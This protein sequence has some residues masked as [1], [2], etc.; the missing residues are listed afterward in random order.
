MPN[1]QNGK[2][3]AIISRNPASANSR[4]I[5]STTVSLGQ[6]MAIHR[7]MHRSGAKKVASHIILD[8]G[9]AY[10]ELLEECPCDSKMELERREGQIIRETANAVNKN[11]A[12]R[13]MAEY[14]VDNKE[15]FKAYYLAHKEQI[16]AYYSSP[17]TK[18]RIKAYYE[19]NK[20][21]ILSVQRKRRDRLA[22]K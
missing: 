9:D 8:Y 15:Q 3:Y 22:A 20:E 6:R 11:I 5:G 13:S 7:S 17:L 16:K 19:A 1:Y 2:I 14:Y 4:Y 10:I 12:G 21:H 18:S